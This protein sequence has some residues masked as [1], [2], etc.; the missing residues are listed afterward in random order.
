MGLFNRLGGNDP[1]NGRNSALNGDPQAMLKD[2]RANPA[3]FMAQAGYS[4]PAGMND[5]RQI[6]D[7]LMQSG[8]L[9]QNRL[10]RAMQIFGQFTRH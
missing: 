6:V 1:T 5:P 8:Q 10:T 4:V 2:L 3:G 9:P 7:H